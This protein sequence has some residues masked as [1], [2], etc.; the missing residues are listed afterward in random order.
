MTRE[1]PPL[2]SARAF[3][4]AARHLSFQEAADELHVT[5]SAISHQVRSLEA[6]LGV[7]LFRR[8]H[9]GVILTAEGDAYLCKLRKAFDTMASATADIKREKLSGR[10]VLGATSA[11][12]SRWIVPR[13]SRFA[14]EFPN[15]NVELKALV[16]ALDFAKQDLDMAVTIGPRDWPGLRADRI[17]ST[18][19]FVICSPKLATA[20]KKPSDLR[21]QTLLHY[22]QGEEWSRWLKKAGV[23][24]DSSAGPRFNDCNVMLQAAV[25]GNGVALS[26]TALARRELE[27]GKL[28]GLFE[29]KISPNAWYYVISPDNSADMPKPTALRKWILKEA[30]SDAVKLAA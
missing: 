9:R 15:I 8:D 29:L 17:M 23:E 3:E 26:F 27:E 1:L 18:P 25:E 4:A 5:P 10:F 22:D 19:L 16:T 2:L 21:S 12:I 28:V 20:M 6:F 7:E 11:F 13:F 14:A 30:Q 24:M